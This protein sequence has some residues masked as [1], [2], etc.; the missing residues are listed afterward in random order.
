MRSAAFSPD[1]RFV[2]TASARQAQVW[3]W[4]TARILATLPA[5]N[6]DFAG[7][8][9]SGATVAPPLMSAA[10]SSCSRR[11]KNVATARAYIGENS[12]LGVNHAWSS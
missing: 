12:S 8:T 4:A 3:E 5:A 6:G 1:G 9:C 11:S 7:T 2:F 10:L